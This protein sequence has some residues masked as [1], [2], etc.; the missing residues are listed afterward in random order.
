MRLNRWAKEGAPERAYEKM[1]EPRV[2]ERA[3]GTAAPDADI[4][5]VY[6]KME[7]VL[8]RLWQLQSPGWSYLPPALIFAP[9]WGQV[10]SSPYLI[11]TKQSMID[12]SVENVFSNIF[13]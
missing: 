7:K 2:T 3:A 13:S 1:T 4:I 8:S 6:V 11:L 5:K 12:R 9:Q 10:F